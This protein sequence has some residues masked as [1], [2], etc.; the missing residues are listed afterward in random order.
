M[1]LLLVE[2]L[3]QDMMPDGEE[4]QTRRKS[5]WDERLRL[6][7]GNE[8]SMRTIGISQPP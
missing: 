2:E 4:D 7:H 6:M 8:E 3:F 5:L 1:T